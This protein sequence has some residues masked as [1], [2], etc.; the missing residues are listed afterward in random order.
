MKLIEKKTI[1]EEIDK[2]TKCYDDKLII[3]DRGILY[4]ILSRDEN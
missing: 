1:M 2:H 3:I 4:S